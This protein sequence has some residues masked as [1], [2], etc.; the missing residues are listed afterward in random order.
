M[1]ILIIVYFFPTGFTDEVITI[2]A[3]AQHV[4]LHPA[5]T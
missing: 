1:I 2:S 4:L 5:A 3:R